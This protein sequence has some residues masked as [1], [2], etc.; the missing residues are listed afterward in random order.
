MSKAKIYYV[1][2]SP[3]GALGAI[4]APQLA[5]AVCSTKASVDAVMRQRRRDYPDDIFMVSWQWKTAEGMQEVSKL[6]KWNF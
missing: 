1:V 3:K 2:R 5:S 4:N 6:E